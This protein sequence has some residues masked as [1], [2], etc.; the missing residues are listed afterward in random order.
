MKRIGLAVAALTLLAGTTVSTQA[1]APAGPTMSIY[2]SV[3]SPY[4]LALD[5]ANNVY[6][7]TNVQFINQPGGKIQTI[8]A[9]NQAISTLASNLVTPAFITPNA[10]NLFVVQ[11]GGTSAN[12]NV[13][14]VMLPGGAASSFIGGNALLNNPLAVA[15][16]GAGNFYVTNDGDSWVI[17]YT[18][19]S[20]T[21]TRWV[22]VPGGVGLADIVYRNGTLYVAHA[23]GTIWTIPTSGPGAGTAS[24]LS[25]TGASIA[26]PVGLTFDSAGDLFVT[27][28]SGGAVYKISTSGA[29]SLY[30]SGAPLSAP[31][32]IVADPAGNLYVANPGDNEVIKIA[33]P[34]QP[35]PALQ[36]WAAAAF[37]TLLAGLGIMTMRGRAA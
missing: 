12:N 32:G 6:V 25:I 36:G 23:T 10:G 7:S 24:P 34:P 14:Q 37:L 28:Q 30:A 31:A 8:A 22:Q 15:F 29:A 21:G 20:D 5:A 11:D 26:N 35:V 17:K 9:S 27:D 2:A 1:G 33:P 13:M 4:G 16:D 19:S 3:P 18:S